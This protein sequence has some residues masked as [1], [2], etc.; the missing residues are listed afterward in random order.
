MKQYKCLVD[1]KKKLERLT[2]ASTDALDVV[3]STIDRLDSI[4]DEIDIAVDEI[5]EVEVELRKT[6]TELKQCRMNNYAI[7]E[8][9]RQLV[10]TN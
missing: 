6:R 9:F 8:K 4:N 10:S 2:K 3:Y 5:A 7:A 1:N